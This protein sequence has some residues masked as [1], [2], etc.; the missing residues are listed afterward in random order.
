MSPSAL[1]LQ[2]VLDARLGWVLNKTFQHETGP[3]QKVCFFV[4]HRLYF[5]EHPSLDS[6]RSLTLKS[7]QIW[8]GLV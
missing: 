4:E 5:V 2:E 6:D 3:A 1:N 8:D 7:F